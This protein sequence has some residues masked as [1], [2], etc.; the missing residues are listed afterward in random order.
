MKAELWEIVAKAEKVIDSCETMEQYRVARTY[1][2]RVE[3]IIGSNHYIWSGLYDRVDN[4][5]KEMLNK[6]L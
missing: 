4:K 2:Y 1:C 5:L 3:D 6:N